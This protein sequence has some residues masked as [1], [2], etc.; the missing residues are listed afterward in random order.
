MRPALIAALFNHS[1]Y[2]RATTA[3]SAKGHRPFRGVSVGSASAHRVKLNSPL[4]SAAVACL[5]SSSARQRHVP[6]AMCHVPCAMCQMPSAKFAARLPERSEMSQAREKSVHRW[7]FA[8]ACCAAQSVLQALRTSAAQVTACSTTR[9]LLA[10]K[11]F[12]LNT[13]RAPCQRCRVSVQSGHAISRPKPPPNHSLNRTHCGM[14]LK[15]RHF[16]LGL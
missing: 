6:C 2:P 14:R 15:A 5:R 4:G 9:V 13:C 10:S 16:I 1:Q 7:R 8:P 11:A 12:G 3:R